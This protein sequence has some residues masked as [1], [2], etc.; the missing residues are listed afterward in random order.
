MSNCTPQDKFLATPL[1][2]WLIFRHAKNKLKTVL[3]CSGAEIN[4]FLVLSMFGSFLTTQMTLKNRIGHRNRN[5]PGVGHPKLV[6]QLGLGP[7]G[8]MS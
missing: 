1:P 8:R 3:A 6:C 4:N 2:K 5:E 7:Q